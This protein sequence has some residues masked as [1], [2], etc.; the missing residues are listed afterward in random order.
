MA[1]ICMLSDNFNAIVNRASVRLILG[2]EVHPKGQA[3]WSK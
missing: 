2:E 1:V 3:L